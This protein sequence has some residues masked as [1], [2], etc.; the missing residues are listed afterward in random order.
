MISELHL[1]SA[2]LQWLG[3]RGETDIP[4]SCV[5]C[6]VRGPKN[7]DDVGECIAPRISAGCLGNNSLKISRAP[8]EHFHI[9]LRAGDIDW[10]S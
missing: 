1:L 6:R 7:S 5:D 9:I 10:S 8:S 2:T 4:S 3:R